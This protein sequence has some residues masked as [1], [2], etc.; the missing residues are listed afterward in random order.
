MI[1]FKQRLGMGENDLL[2]QNTAGPGPLQKEKGGKRGRNRHQP[3]KCLTA[4]RK[5]K[6]HAQL[7]AGKEG[8]RMVTVYDLRGEDGCDLFPKGPVRL[9]PLM[10]AQ[11]MGGKALNITGTELGLQTLPELIPPAVKGADCLQDLPALLL[12]GE[13]A[14]AGRM[15]ASRQ[16]HIPDSPY[17]DHKKLV[18]IA[19]EN[20]GKFQPL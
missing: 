11:F 19:G 4:L 8:E 16:G 3:Q 1:S 9:L 12:R 6:S 13:A 17:P 18:Q 7:F 14:F 20:G 2:Y 15:A 5:G 10:I